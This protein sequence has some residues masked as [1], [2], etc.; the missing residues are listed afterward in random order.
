VAA[1]PDAALAGDYGPVRALAGIAALARDFDGFILDQWGVLHDG[2]RP[3]PGA[4][5]CLR[6]LREHG[7]RVVILSNSGRRE[8]ENVRLMASMGFAAALFE[9]CVSAGE[10]AREALERRTNA[11]HARLGRRYFAFLR[12][13]NA[14]LLEG[15]ALERTSRVEQAE[16]LVVIGID[17]PERTL[18]SYEEDLARGAEL[19]L[20]MVC[21]NPDIAR[22]SPEG[23]VD[24]PGVLARRYEELGGEVFYH[25]KPYPAIYASCLQA[26]G[27]ARERVIA[28]GDSLDHDVLGA[29]RAGLAS[30]FLAGGIHMHELGGEWGS[31]PDAR[32]WREFVEKAPAR[33]GYLVPAF[34]W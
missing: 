29:A 18:A 5:E 1:S 33:P 27:C 21:A 19:G 4:A 31:L 3:Y 26:L 14:S 30:A 22:V 15:L 20:P 34:V 25:G 16:F 2:T 32:A 10:D 7:K 23:L 24:A 17:S 9:R 13:G 6:R 11:F 8:A 12:G 28:I